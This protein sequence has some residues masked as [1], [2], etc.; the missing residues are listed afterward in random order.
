VVKSRRIGFSEVAA[1]KRAARA[2][3]L[4]LRSDGFKRCKPASQN[5]LSASWTQSKALLKR[6]MVHV[7]ALARI[8]GAARV[9]KRSESLVELSNGC[10]LVALSTN[11]RTGRGYKGDVLLDEWASAPRQKELFTAIGPL[12]DPTI[13]T[14]EG[15]D[16]DVVSTP[17]GD[18]DMFYKMFEGDLS[19]GWSKHR[20]TWRDA[21]A[22]GF[23]ITDKWIAEKRAQYDEEM[24]AQEYECDFMAANTRYISAELYDAA[25]YYDDDPA[26]DPNRRSLADVTFYG[27]LDVAP[28]R[29][30]MSLCKL[31][32]DGD[33]VAWHDRTYAWRGADIKNIPPGKNVWDVHEERVD[34]LARCLK[35]LAVDKTGV[36]SQF[37]ARLTNRFGG[38]VDEVDFNITTKEEMATGM[39]LGLQRKRLR[40]RADDTDTRREVLSMK[41]EITP[42]GNVRFDIERS[43][44]SHGD[45]AWAMA[46]AFRATGTATRTTRKA[47]AKSAAV[48]APPRPERSVRVQRGAWR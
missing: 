40:P 45:K 17:L 4:R 34:E 35:A 47:V 42:M 29:D 33:G 37:A 30:L 18:N 10:V 13:D 3:G 39:K 11:P 9:V 38:R 26:W 46:L 7:D 2:H 43:Q 27:G 14:P 28:M 19:E 15:F 48:E 23:P 31:K 22:D 41:R 1:F 8:P 32:K 44:K 25:I 20:V 5:L 16:I 24:F 6:V 12:A 36:G 21:R